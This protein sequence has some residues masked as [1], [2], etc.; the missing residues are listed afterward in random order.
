MKLMLDAVYRLLVNRDTDLPPRLPHSE[1]EFAGL[2][3]MFWTCP[4]F[5]LGKR[6]VRGALKLLKRS[7]RFWGVWFRGASQYSCAGTARGRVSMFKMARAHRGPISA[8]QRSNAPRLR[9]IAVR[10]HNSCEKPR[11]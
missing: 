11:R 4:G 5:I 9:T 8:G 2:D 3:F 7:T 6:V 1:R 10:A